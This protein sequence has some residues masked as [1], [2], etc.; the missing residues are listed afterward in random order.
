MRRLGIIA[1]S[2][3]AVCLAVAG[4][5]STV[6]GTALV[7]PGGRTPGTVTA[8]GLPAL[9]LS[10][11]EMKQ[12]LKFSGMATEDGWTR[13]EARGTFEPSSCVGA[14]FSSMAGSYDNSGYRELYEV[15]QSDVSGEFGRTG[16]IKAALQSNIARRQGVLSPSRSPNGGNSPAVSSGTPIRGRMTGRTP[17]GSATRSM[18]VA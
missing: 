15:R 10:L 11:D 4:C 1:V 14:V 5:T 6:G 7:G 9:L 8:R 13:L 17:T 16:L 3:W 2:A 12:L 18:P